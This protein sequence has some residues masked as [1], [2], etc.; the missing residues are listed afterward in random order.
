MLENLAIFSAAPIPMG[1]Y[2][3]KLWWLI[4]LALEPWAGEPSFQLGKRRTLGV[5]H[6][7]VWGGTYVNKQL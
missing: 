5:V 2:S 6:F 7:F 3:Q 4:F 1:L